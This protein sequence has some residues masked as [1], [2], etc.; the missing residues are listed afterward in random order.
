MKYMVISTSRH[1]VFRAGSW[2]Y[3]RGTE[4]LI[5]SVPAPSTA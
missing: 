4:P 3:M 5:V 2:M 1:C